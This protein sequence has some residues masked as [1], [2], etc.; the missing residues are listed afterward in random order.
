MADIGFSVIFPAFNE[1]ENINTTINNALG[2]L[3][4]IN[5]AWEIIIVNDGS[6]DKTGILS[7]EICRRE[8]RVRAIHHSKNEGYGRALK[9]GFASSRYNYIFF[10]D[11]DGQFDLRDLDKMWPLAKEGI[12]ELII[13]Y[14]FKRQDN[15]LRRFLGWLYN[16]LVYLLFD[17]N[18]KDIDCAFKIF[19]RSVFEKINIDSNN[20][21]VN[22]EILIKARFLNYKILQVGVSHFPRRAGRSTVSLKKILLT[23]IELQRQY[24]SSI[25]LKIK[26]KCKES[27]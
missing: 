5:D 18:V 21:F 23:L 14:R 17:L 4:T 27:K 20:F 25:K 1:E 15:L 19:K 2:Y 3:K 11:S 26:R 9:D 6:E 24:Y 12:A 22:T 10:T 16:R 7:E 8:P 13:G